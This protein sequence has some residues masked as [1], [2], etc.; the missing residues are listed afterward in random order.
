LEN[1][2]LYFFAIFGSVSGLQSIAFNLLSL[3]QWSFSHPSW[4][5]IVFT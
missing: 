3:V 4:F 2:V 1:F 5:Y